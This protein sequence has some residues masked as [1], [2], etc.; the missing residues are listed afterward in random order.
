MTGR[1]LF[2]AAG[3][4]LLAGLIL[5]AAGLWAVPAGGTPYVRE[6]AG[7]IV[8]GNTYLEIVFDK[9]AN[10]GIYAFKNK[11]GRID[12]RTNKAAPPALFR[13][14]ATKRTVFDNRETTKFRSVTRKEADGSI[15]V[16]LV[17]EHPRT[18]M[19][20]TASVTVHP[21]DPLADFALDIQNTGPLSLVEVEFP[22]L[23]GNRGLGRSSSDDVLVYPGWGTSRLVQDPI[24]T[25]DA[26]C[27]FKD[28]DCY[29]GVGKRE[30]YPGWASTQMLAFYDPAGGFYLATYD[31]RMH[32]KAF[33][34]GI[35]KT[36]NLRISIRHL[37][38][39]LPR[40]GWRSPYPIKV[41]TF[42]GDWYDAADMY[43]EWARKQWW[44][45]KRVWEKDT[46]EW[47]LQGISF[48]HFYN[49]KEWAEA[50]KIPD[51]VYKLHDIAA[52]TNAY[53]KKWGVPL[54][55][56]IH[57]WERTKRS[58]PNPAKHNLVPPYVPP[59]EGEESF[60]DAVDLL[61]R[62]GNYSMVYVGAS[63]YGG[64]KRKWRDPVL[65]YALKNPRGRPFWSWGV[66]TPYMDPTTIFWRKELVG[67]TLKVLDL[68]VDIVQM[69][70][71]PTAFPQYRPRPGHPMGFGSWIGEAWTRTIGAVRKAAKERNPKVVLTSEEICEVY[72]PLL[73]SY[74]S[75]DNAPDFNYQTGI[76]KDKVHKWKTIPLFAY[77]YHP[78]ITTFGQIVVSR[79][80]IAR[81]LVRGKMPHLAGNTRD[82]KV[83]ELFRKAARATHT[84]ARDYILFGEM[85]RPAHISAPE[86]TTK[87][88]FFAN[89]DVKPEL[90][91][92]SRALFHSAW[93]YQGKVAYFFVNISDSPV[94]FTA[95][96]DPPRLPRDH[97]TIREVRDGEART[98]E[99]SA[100][101]P[102][103]V[104]LRVEPDQILMLE[105]S[106]N[107]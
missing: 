33:M 81:G 64:V 107:R 89:L 60:R 43:K 63:L 45:R 105:V 78:Y 37:L 9:A 80:G 73:D 13:V 96:L 104:S 100:S 8:L 58:L 41:G 48:L 50:K 44:A 90:P 11:K 79:Y 36:R 83:L 17:S 71:W 25:W 55:A 51:V 77:V 93:Y 23:N 3:G 16:E 49:Y 7:K 27:D 70:T 5:V 19:V 74:V 106:K 20:L 35:W 67:T 68:G 40:K 98:L 34:A 88:S 82:E 18:G 29:G 30:I 66:N 95:K 92:K 28:K 57:C 38:Q 21:D 10:G 103:T 69:D 24:H 84:Y 42:Q 52:R 14:R 94:S 22:V 6:D 101:L 26:D 2:P 75:R 65:E 56:L 86:I 47:F 99:R 53:S 97:L 61:H 62:E 12:Y 31:N 32:T 102:R 85:L 87:V 4:F 54:C 72:I 39:I 91:L 46:P 76:P 1:R 59:T 15:R